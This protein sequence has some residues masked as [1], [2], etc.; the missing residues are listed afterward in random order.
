MDIDDMIID[1][2]FFTNRM[3]SII[4]QL[5]RIAN[6]SDGF[7][8]SNAEI[9]K[10]AELLLKIGIAYGF[11]KLPDNYCSREVRVIDDIV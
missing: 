10:A 9:L 2:E 11:T 7:E 6:K 5:W 1:R 4:I 3:E 8:S